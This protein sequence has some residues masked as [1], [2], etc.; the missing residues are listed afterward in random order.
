MGR[1]N[2]NSDDKNFVKC[3]ICGKNLIERTDDGLLRFKFGTQKD[4]SG[5]TTRRPVD[6]I[7]CGSVKIKCIRRKCNHWTT[8][9][10]LPFG[11]KHD[12]Q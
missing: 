6:M 11:S 7:I 12:K 3:E 1:Q 4:D 9:P 10:F 2:M 8:V 5:N